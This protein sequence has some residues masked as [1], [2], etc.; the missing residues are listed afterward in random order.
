MPWKR[1]QRAE[2]RDDGVDWQ[3]WRC[4]GAWLDGGTAREGGKK[5]L[6]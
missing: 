2:E 4:G 1:Q 3:W 6:Q 5:K